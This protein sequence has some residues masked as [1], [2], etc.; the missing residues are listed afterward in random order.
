MSVRAV[1][2]GLRDADFIEVDEETDSLG[3]TDVFRKRVEETSKTLASDESTPVDHLVSRGLDGETAGRLLDLAPDSEKLVAVHETVTGT[4]PEYDRE[5]LLVLS[6]QLEQLLEGAPPSDGAPAAFFPVD[7]DRIDLFGALYGRTVVYIWRRDCPP[8]DT[9][10]GDLDYI[11]GGTPDDLGLLA[12]YGP[13]WVNLLDEEY[14]V[15]G[16]PTILFML[17]T[18]VDSRIIRDPPREVIE[19]EVETLRSL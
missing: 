10:R 6:A 4:V 5:E 7:A 8:C 18:R 19:G 16:G 14:D 2:D 13:D 11:F 12:V 17:G 15:V 3:V 9:V 1:V